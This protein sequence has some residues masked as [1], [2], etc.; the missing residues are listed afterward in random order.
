MPS[1]GAS[2]RSVAT[3]IFQ[4]GSVSHGGILDTV[5]NAD[6]ENSTDQDLARVSAPPRFL[7]LLLPLGHGQKPCAAWVGRTSQLEAKIYYDVKHLG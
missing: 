1:L 5:S 6:A 2:E 3:E 7:S 4:S